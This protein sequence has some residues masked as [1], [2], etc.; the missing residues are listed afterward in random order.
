MYISK[1]SIVGR[2]II[3]SFSSWNLDIAEFKVNSLSSKSIKPEF[4]IFLAIILGSPYSSNW[5]TTVGKNTDD[6]FDINGVKSKS[7]FRID[8]WSIFISLTKEANLKD[9]LRSN[10]KNVS[11]PMP[12]SSNSCNNSGMVFSQLH[13]KIFINSTNIPCLTSQAP[14]CRFNNL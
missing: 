10:L 5:Y 11:N 3:Y 8:F 4:W 14:G 7:D 6:N 1:G 12:I 9:T 13:Y 2:D